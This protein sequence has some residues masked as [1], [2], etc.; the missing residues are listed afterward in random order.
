MKEKENL[1]T[2]KHGFTQIKKDDFRFQ[3]SNF[4]FIF[5]NFSFK[6]PCSSV[7]ICGQFL[8]NLSR[9]C[10]SAVN[11]FLIVSLVSAQ[12][13]VLIPTDENKPNPKRL[14]LAVMNVEITIDNQHATVKV[15]QIFDNH[16]DRTLEGKYVF[17][18]PQRSSISD[19]A[20][21]EN[22]S[23]FPGVMM[24]R[25]R[26]N[27][28]YGEIK[29]AQIDPGILQTTDETESAS[30]F[31]AKIFPINSYGTKRLEMEYTEDLPIENLASQFTF[32]L[33]PTYGESQTVGEFNLKIRV[34][35]DFPFAPFAA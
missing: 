12:S 9:L 21:W 18:L 26:A 17:A 1:S 24:E 28:V 34:L 23:R 32:P 15:M 4:R 27:R 3:I 16:T 31:S 22:E 2:D 10:A 8:K 20:V 6:N 7:F 35:N 14:S 13:G 25:R 11:I 30:G 29:Q 33:K 5:S 19:F